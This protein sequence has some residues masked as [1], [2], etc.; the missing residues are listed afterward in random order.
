[1][2]RSF[3]L[4]MG[5]SLLAV[6]CEAPE[7]AA[8]APRTIAPRAN[9]LAAATEPTEPP[10]RSATS[11]K[12]EGTRGEVVLVVLGKS[13]PADLIDEIEQALRDELQVEVIRHERIPLPKAAY[14]APRRRYR[15]DKLLDHLLTLIPKAPATTRVL[16]LTTSDISTTKGKHKDW[17]I[18]GLGL[19]PGQAAVIS[20]HRLQRG[21]KTR[22]KL[23]FRVATTAVHEIGHTFGL[24][25][26]PEARCPMQDAEGS[27]RNTDT[28]TGHLG[29]TCRRALDL[30]FPQRLTP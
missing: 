27:I 5:I 20:S 11:T 16:G 7:P 8:P 4:A 25:H 10:V 12:G 2:L 13:F 17:G 3:C 28:S 9:V 22:E 6:A 19:M 24:D 21:A 29:P 26:C 23:R 14:T 15:A 1:M 18:F 30:A